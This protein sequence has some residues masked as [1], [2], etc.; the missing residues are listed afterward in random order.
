MLKFP[1]AN[2]LII[3]LFNCFNPFCDLY[4]QKDKNMYRSHDCGTLRIENINSE[5]TL[6]GWV[7][8]TRDFGGMTFLDL[9]DRYGITQLVFN[10]ETNKPLC[11]LARTLGR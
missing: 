7:Q 5:I 2:Y 11:E 6:A 9:R 8:R 3:S 10:M 1:L 4:P